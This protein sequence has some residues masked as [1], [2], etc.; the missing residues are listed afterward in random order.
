MNLRIDERFKNNVK[1]VFEKYEFEVG[2]LEDKKYRK[3]LRGE[4]GKKGQDVLT[5]YAGTKVRKASQKRTDIDISEISK[6]NRERYDYLRKPFKTK[7]T[8]IQRLLNDFFEFAF[9]RTEAKRL[10]NTLQ[11]VVRN[12]ILRKRYG[13]NSSLTKAIKGFDHVMIDTAQFFKA[14]KAKVKVRKL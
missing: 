13:S 2:I 5:T 8:E 10:E 7:S 1:G 4:R 6:E 9:G 11:A 12:P 14:I 3:P